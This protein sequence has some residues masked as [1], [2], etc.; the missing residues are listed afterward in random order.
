MKNGVGDLFVTPMLLFL[1]VDCGGSKTSAVICDANSRIVG[2]ALSGPSNFANIPL[3]V[4]VDTVHTVVSNVLPSTSTPLFTA[5]WFGIAGIDSP[6]AVRMALAALS[7]EGVFILDSPD[8]DDNDGHPP[9]PAFSDDHRQ[10]PCTMY[11]CQRASKYTLYFLSQFYLL[12]FLSCIFALP[13]A[14]NKPLPMIT[15]T[16]LPPQQWPY[17]SFS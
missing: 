17:P 12:I 10:L 14:S 9:A 1:C 2:H 15:T 4:F 7:E 16:C 3:P 6:A 11:Q 5:A 8:G 13:T